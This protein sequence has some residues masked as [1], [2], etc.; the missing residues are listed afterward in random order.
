MNLVINGLMGI[1][2]ARSFC[3]FFLEICNFV[4]LY[5]LKEEW[6][7]LQNNVNFIIYKYSLKDN[8]SWRTCILN[9]IL[10]N[11]P[12]IFHVMVV[13]KIF[14]PYSAG[15]EVIS[16]CQQYRARPFCTFVQSDLALYCWLT[17]FW[18][19][20]NING[21]FQKWKVENHI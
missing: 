21:Q 16:L 15:T 11:V 6:L 9:R 20:W 19:P 14:N 17:T 3:N 8:V 10:V 12:F 7:Y 13:L 18:Y 5:T 2:S 4:V 1:Y